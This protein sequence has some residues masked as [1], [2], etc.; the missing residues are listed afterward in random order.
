MRAESGFKCER[1]RAPELTGPGQTLTVN[2]IRRDLPYTNRANLVVLCR[3]CQGQLRT[4]H[5]DDLGRQLELFESYELHWLRPHL[6]GLG[7]LVPG[8]RERNN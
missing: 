5:L 4:V 8:T 6:E 7:L 2:L 1:C 3:R